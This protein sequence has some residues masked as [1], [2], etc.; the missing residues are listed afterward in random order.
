MA[1]KLMKNERVLRAVLQKKTASPVNKNK[2]NFD[3]EFSFST[4]SGEDE[5][6]EIILYD[7]PKRIDRAASEWAI[8]VFV[9][10][11]HLIEIVPFKKE[12]TENEFIYECM[13]KVV[14]EFTCEGSIFKYVP[15]ITYLVNQ[16]YRKH[17]IQNKLITMIEVKHF[18]NGHK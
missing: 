15:R 12:K 18:L 11:P 10:K 9:E 5:K 6:L 13:K 2:K 14:S 4:P 16:E 3:V 17:R 1:D 8:S 7:T